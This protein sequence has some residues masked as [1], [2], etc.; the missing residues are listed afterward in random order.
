[1]TWHKSKDESPS[2]GAFVLVKNDGE[3]CDV[4]HIAVAIRAV[5]DRDEPLKIFFFPVRFNL[6]HSEKSETFLIVEKQENHRVTHWQYVEPHRDDVRALC[7]RC[8]GL[9]ETLLELTETNTK[10]AARLRAAGVQL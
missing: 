4:L 9:T 6:T 8:I 3:C 7:R 5:R 1:M 2:D 10:Q